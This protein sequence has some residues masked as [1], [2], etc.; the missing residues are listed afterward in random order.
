MIKSKAFDESDY[1]A[2]ATMSHKKGTECLQTSS[3]AFAGN[4]TRCSTGHG[5]GQNRWAQVENH[6]APMVMRST[7]GVVVTNVQSLSGISTWGGVS[8]GTPR[9]KISARSTCA[10]AAG[11]CTTSEGG[12]YSQHVR[13]PVESVSPPQVSLPAKPKAV[14]PTGPGPASL[15]RQASGDNCLLQFYH[16]LQRPTKAEVVQPGRGGGGYLEA[17]LVAPENGDEITVNMGPQADA[18]ESGTPIL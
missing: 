17:R 8:D 14:P 16:Y 15:Q 2:V 5:T 1:S 3:D 12:V 10:L 9:A 13:T 11:T 7:S 4:L 6:A 18:V